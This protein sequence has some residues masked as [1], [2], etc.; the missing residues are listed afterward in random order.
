MYE[1]AHS[2]IILR[3]KADGRNY[4]TLRHKMGMLTHEEPEVAVPDGEVQL[5]IEGTPDAYTYSYSTDGKT[6]RKL[7]SLNAR[8]LS[9][10]TVGGFTGIMLGLFATAGSDA[11]KATAEYDYFDY[12]RK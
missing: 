2:D 11:S 6:Y 8:Y 7:G 3:R 1:D 9:T 4:I 10:E 12:E 5:R